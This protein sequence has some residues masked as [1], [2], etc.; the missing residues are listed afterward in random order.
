MFT[1]IKYKKLINLMEIDSFPQLEKKEEV[2]LIQQV[3]LPLKW[4]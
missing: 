3:H 1:S 4:S 2:A